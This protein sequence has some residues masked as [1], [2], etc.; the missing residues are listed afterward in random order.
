[1]SQQDNQDQDWSELP[2]LI[3]EKIMLL[4]GLSSLESLD[5]CRQVCRAWNVAIMRKLR[6]NPSKS[7]GSIIR[8]R[9]EKSW[10][11]GSLPSD[12]KIV[13]AKLLGDH[14]KREYHQLGFL[15]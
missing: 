11:P 2:D 5:N 14:R 9:I 10:G 13:H 6:E 8:R 15:I 4:M 12:Q 1:M 7:W 3:L